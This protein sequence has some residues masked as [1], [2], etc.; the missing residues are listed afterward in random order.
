MGRFQAGRRVANGPRGLPPGHRP[1]FAYRVVQRLPVHV[2]HDDID[3]AALLADLVDGHGVGVVQLG[4]Q[5]GLAEEPLE[6]IGV[7]RKA[8]RQG[9]DGHVAVQAGIVG[10]PDLAHAPFTQPAKERVRANLPGR[11]GLRQ[12]NRFGQRFGLLSIRHCPL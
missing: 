10:Q 9:L 6:A 8:G 12:R 4:R 7:V 2:L 1:A 5:A 3:Q 11:R